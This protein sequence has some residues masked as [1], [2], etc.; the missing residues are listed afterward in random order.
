MTDQPAPP[1]CTRE[2]VIDTLTH[3]ARPLKRWDLIVQM[4][5]HH[6]STNLD[7]V[8]DLPIGAAQPYGEL[9][10][11]MVKTGELVFLPGPVWRQFLGPGA[12]PPSVHPGN[13]YLA[14]KTQHAEWAIPFFTVVGLRRDA[15]AAETLIA[16]VLEHAVPDGAWR[17]DELRSEDGWTRMATVVQASTAREAEQLARSLWSA[18][19]AADKAG[20]TA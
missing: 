20:V 9:I 13:H 1:P 8:Y 2:A 15:D 14:T 16:A 11:A 17:S 4:Y 5:R 3:Y 19:G 12:T 18:D 6:G 7:R 10:D